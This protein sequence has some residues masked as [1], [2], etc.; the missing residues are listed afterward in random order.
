MGI[1]SFRLHTCNKKSFGLP[2]WDGRNT[3]DG[4]MYESDEEDLLDP[5]QNRLL[6]RGIYDYNPDA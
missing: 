5:L 2:L 3:L 4:F 1:E 6:R